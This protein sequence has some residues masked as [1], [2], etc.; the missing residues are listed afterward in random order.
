MLSS[1][2]EL[3]GRIRNDAI[4]A[5]SL[6]QSQNDR[7]T[8]LKVLLTCVLLCWASGTQAQSCVDLYKAV[9]SE[10]MYCGFF[11]DQGKLELS[12]KTYTASCIRIVLSPSLF[13]LDSVPQ[14]SSPLAGRG[15]LTDQ[16]AV[17]EGDVR[18]RR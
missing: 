10:A 17:L 18:L 1:K 5:A 8:R 15:E 4:C 11:C 16:T 12:Q 14:E 13:D 3:N 2:L 9:K 7:W 6:D